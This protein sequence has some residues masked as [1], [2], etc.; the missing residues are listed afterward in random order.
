MLL[1]LLLSAPLAAAALADT[2]PA[3]DGTQATLEVRHSEQRLSGN[4]VRLGTVVTL[5]MT[6]APANTLGA[7]T[8]MRILLPRGRH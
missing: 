1:V 3:P 5:T 4:R 7:I 8:G 2:A 6:L